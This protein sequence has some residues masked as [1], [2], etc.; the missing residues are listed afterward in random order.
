MVL[1]LNS[2]QQEEPPKPQDDV[3]TYDIYWNVDREQYMVQTESGLS[4]RKRDKDGFWHIRF[5]VNGQL[6]ELKVADGAIVS[7]ID[8]ARAM[9]LEFDAEGTVIGVIDI[10]DMPV[11]KAAW[12]FFVKSVG[13]KKVKFNSSTSFEGINAELTLA[14]NCEIYDMTGHSGEPGTKTELLEMDRVCAFANEDGEV[15]LIFVYERQIVKTITAYCDECKEEA[16]WVEWTDTKTLPIVSG[17]YFLSGDVTL[18]DQQSILENNTKI[19]LDLNGK[20]VTGA[21]NCRVYALFEHN[22]VLSIFDNSEAKTGVIKAIGESPNEG[23]VIWVRHKDGTCNLYGGTLDGSEY[24]LINAEVYEGD[25]IYYVGK[26]GATVNTGGTFNMYNGTIIGGTAYRAEN[27]P[28]EY[29]GNGGAVCVMPHNDVEAGIFNMYDG[30]IYGGIA[31]AGG[32]IQLYGEMNMYGGKI[33][34]GQTKDAN[35]KLIQSTGWENMFIVN[36]T[37]SMSGGEIAGHVQAIDTAAGDKYAATINLSGTAVIY[38]AESG[39]TNITLHAG[40][41]DGV[42]INV[43]KM[44]EGAC[45]GITASGVFTTQTDAENAKY[46]ISD[47]PGTFVAYQGGLAVVLKTSSI[48][49]CECGDKAVGMPG[50]TCTD[51]T[52]TEVPGN[53][54]LNP[55]F[56]VQGGNYKL[57]GNVTLTESIVV[58]ASAKQ[59]RIDLNGYTLSVGNGSRVV[60]TWLATNL[61]ILTITDS[62]A[63]GNGKIRV[64]G[65]ANTEG[66]CVAATNNV[67]FKLYGGTLDASGYTMTSDW[68]GGA[69]VFVFG[70][71]KFYMYGGQILG[72]KCTL[73]NGS[74]VDIYSE[75]AAMTMYGGV[76]RG[77]YSDNSGGNIRVLGSMNL[78][79]GEVYG[80][81]VKGSGGNLLLVGTF[82]MTGGKI[83][84]GSGAYGYNIASYGGTM[85]LSGGEIAGGVMV[86]GASK[87]NLSGNIKINAGEDYNLKLGD[88]AA[89]V[90]VGELVVGETANIKVSASVGR[91]FATGNGV[92]LNDTNKAFFSSEVESTEITVKDG[93]FAITLEATDILGCE[94]GG[95]AVGNE[96]H[97]CNELSWIEV[98]A[99]EALNPSFFAGGGSFKL[100]GDVT[101]TDQIIISGSATELHIDLNGYT[102]TKA[103]GERVING[104]A[105]SNLVSLTI[106]D[107]SEAGTGKIT[108]NITKAN[109]PEVMYAAYAQLRMGDG[110]CW[111]GDSGH[112]RMCAEDAVVVRDEKGVIEPQYSYVLMHEQ[113]VE[114]INPEKMTYSMCDTFVKYSFDQLFRGTYLPVTVPELAG[115]AVDVPTCTLEGGLEEDNRFALT[116]GIVKA[117]YSLDYVTMVITDE[118]GN[119]VFNHWMFPS[120]TKRLDNNSND[121]QIRCLIM[122]FDLAG[123][124]VPLKYVSLESGKTYHAVITGNLATGDSF[125]VK[126]FSFTNG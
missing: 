112:S 93:G 75:T 54:A 65:T 31:N 116:T 85:N 56:F 26:H 14:E 82:N 50:H 11:T 110:V 10:D 86:E 106:T 58:S 118:T 20:T 4:A 13:K 69:A 119:E 98:P 51:L 80:G 2:N 77:G 46:F 23:G 97:T 7:A 48:E 113:G 33:Y 43:G 105:A 109:G 42:K 84:G 107:S 76:I 73:Q 123:Y 53:S 79:G 74:A 124:A 60:N 25:N 57:M 126:D 17:H 61:E 67:V 41:G 35:G 71:S 59:L 5:F 115:A 49:M 28:W 96:H 3:Q 121:Y 87:V 102:L 89:V 45:I 78:H 36:G 103:G 21:R 18:R 91:V 122:E 114:R 1:F 99:N 72:G 101:V 27:C 66:G 47:T 15:Y 8:S 92:E 34:G 24:Y 40:S 12:N 62:S 104:W 111:N 64:F 83:Y 100:M 38:G 19:C 117:N 88:E 39:Y 63:S 68:A 55:A 125:V 108:E 29:A 16:Q 44:E 120:V 81:S 52:W 6:T 94:C 30:E 37:F 22:I 70:N 95:R 32:N 90:V 9:G